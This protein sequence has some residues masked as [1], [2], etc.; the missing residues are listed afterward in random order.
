M[1]ICD[2]QNMVRFTDLDGYILWC[3]Q[4]RG[5]DLRG[6]IRSYT[7]LN[8]D[9]APNYGEL[10]GCLRRAVLAGAIPLPSDG[11]Y[12]LTPEWLHR[13]RAWDS[14]YSIPEDRMIAF[15]E[16]I[17]SQEFPVVNPTEFVV[18]REEYEA[19]IGQLQGAIRREPLQ[20]VSHSINLYHNG[21]I[22]PGEMWYMIARALTPETANSVL[23]GLPQQ[24]Q[25]HLRDV[26]FERPSLPDNEE[27]AAVCRQLVSWCER[28]RAK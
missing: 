3:L 17:S 22:C 28:G 18:E 14:Q 24:T 23:N 4:Y 8:R 16:W 7:F 9:A 12:G 2:G 26:Y 13:N 15:S 19:A 27:F 1:P 11:H 21:V 20:E 10:V 25:G 6:L 5:C